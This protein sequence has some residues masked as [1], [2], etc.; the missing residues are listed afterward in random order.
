MI[1]KYDIKLMEYCSDIALK[2]D[3]RS[4]HGCI[5]V[6][7]NG[8]IIS[9]AYNKTLNISPHKLKNLNKDDKFS[10]HAEENALNNVDKTKLYGAKLYV[11]RLGGNIENNP[12][13]LNSK[14]CKRCTSII[15]KCMKKFGL[16]RVYY[17]ID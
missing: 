1:H 9:T 14:P 17:S 10:V 2:S 4:K 11:I 12:L 16:K 3:M 6:D 7:K 8:N 5:I 15:E 13:I